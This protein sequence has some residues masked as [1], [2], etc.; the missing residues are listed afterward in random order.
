MVP[1]S[2]RVLHAQFSMYLNKPNEA[3]ERLYTL[4]NT[5]NKI[6]KN[7]ESGKTEDGSIA[8]L[9]PDDREASIT[10]WNDRSK[11]LLFCIGNVLLQTREYEAAIKTYELILEKSEGDAVYLQS[12]IGRALLQLGNIKSAQHRFAKAEQAAK[13]DPN[14]KLQLIMNRAFLYLG[15]SNWKEALTQFNEVLKLNPQ[16]LE[17][18]NNKSVC[19]LYLCRLKDAISSLETAVWMQNNDSKDF[20]QN[21]L[22]LEGALSNLVTLY[23]L[24]SSRFMTKKQTLL[25]HI[26]GIS[27]DGFDVTCLKM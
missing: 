26:A 6:L 17:A 13:E 4:Q 1:F 15:T 12:G 7:L 8:E 23:E 24:E 18:L 11:T 10:L 25:H 14:Y 21:Q 9:K 20:L 2:M 5:S 16:H 27:G 19:L 3:L 22:P